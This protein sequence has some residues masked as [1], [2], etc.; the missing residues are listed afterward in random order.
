M[1]KIEDTY[2]KKFES[3]MNNDMDTPSAL[4]NATHTAKKIIRN[5]KKFDASKLQ[6]SL[7]KMLKV[8][9]FVF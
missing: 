9:G 2:F 6:A 7:R 8:L 3:F 5:G 1:K 4:I